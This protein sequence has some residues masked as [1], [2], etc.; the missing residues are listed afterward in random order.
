MGTL[1]FDHSP[2][3]GRGMLEAV[4]CLS[5]EDTGQIVGITEAAQDISF[6]EARDADV[7]LR[8]GDG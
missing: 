5:T 2:W 7:A 1:S 6:P 8:S 3:H 4:R